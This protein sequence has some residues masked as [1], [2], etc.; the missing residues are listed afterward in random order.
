MTGLPSFSGLQSW[1][2]AVPSIERTQSLREDNA[3]KDKKKLPEHVLQIHHQKC[4]GN[5]GFCGWGELCHDAS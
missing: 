2:F 4:H 1:G 3:Q 5:R